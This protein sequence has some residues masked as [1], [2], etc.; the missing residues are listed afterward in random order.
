MKLER[1]I[2]SKQTTPFKTE[3]RNKYM[4][5]SQYDLC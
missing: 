4:K 2:V 5:A 3:M 1:K